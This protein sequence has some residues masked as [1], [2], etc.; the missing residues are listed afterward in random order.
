MIGRLR[1]R[2]VDRA[3][4]LVIVECGG[5]G[6]EVHVS[7]YTLAELGEP[8]EDVTLQIHTH[9]QENRVALFG[10]SS[11]QERALFDLLVTVKNV[12]ASSAIKILSAGAGP[13]EIASMI[14]SEKVALLQAIKGVGKKTAE[15]LVVELRDRCEKLLLSWGQAPDCPEGDN[16]DRPRAAVIVPP[17]AN[18]PLVDDVSAALSQLGWRPA[19]VDRAIANLDAGAGESL[20]ELL[21]QA[22]RSMAR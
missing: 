4:A 7:A 22:L 3:G 8:G 13:Y 19:E 2:Y 12:G 1:G 6:Y 14:R 21:R 17:G 15:L 11:R 20:E 18:N 16:A 5:V 9:A 10:F